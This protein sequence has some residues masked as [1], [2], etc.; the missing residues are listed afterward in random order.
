MLF[1]KLL[2]RWAHGG[3]AIEA[4]IKFNFNMFILSLSNN[5]VAEVALS[6]PT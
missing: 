6:D 1:P 4:K 5:I 2:A 3:R